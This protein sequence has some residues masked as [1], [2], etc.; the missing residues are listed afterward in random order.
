MIADDRQSREIQCYHSTSGICCLKMMNNLSDAKGDG[1][2]HS[3][4]VMDGRRDSS[5]PS[6]CQH[7]LQATGKILFNVSISHFS[8]TL[9]SMEFS[10]R[11]VLPLDSP[12]SSNYPDKTQVAVQPMTHISLKMLRDFSAQVVCNLFSVR[13]NW[14][15]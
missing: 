9:I 6:R 8:V 12:K 13:L 5:S 2:E 10:L 7:M 1:T 15:I 4:V 3:E 14:V 11:S